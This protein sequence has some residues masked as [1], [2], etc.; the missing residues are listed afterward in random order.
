MNEDNW[1]ETTKMRNNLKIMMK[2]LGKT[3]VWSEMQATIE[4]EWIA[5]TREKEGKE[6]G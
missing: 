2:K 1:I 3:I 6:R 5:E 4:E